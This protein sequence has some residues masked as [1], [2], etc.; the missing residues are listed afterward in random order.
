MFT[1]LHRIMLLQDFDIAWQLTWKSNAFSLTLGYLDNTTVVPVF[2]KVS[3][4]VYWC[5]A[6]ITSTG[7][8]D[9]IAYSNLE[10]GKFTVFEYNLLHCKARILCW[11]FWPGMKESVL[12]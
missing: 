2:D 11:V 12:I 4:S 1:F 7:Y 6:T 9:M 8:G 3:D 10:M 5:V